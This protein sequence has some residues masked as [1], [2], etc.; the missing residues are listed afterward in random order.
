MIS[1]GILIFSVL[2]YKPLTYNRTYTYPVWAQ[3]LGWTLALVPMSV[4]PAHFFWDLYHRPGTLRQVHFFSK[5]FNLICA[6]ESNLIIY[7]CVL[8]RWA[9][10]TQ[11]VLSADHPDAPKSSHVPEVITAQL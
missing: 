7:L 6:F 2:A 3:A 1:Q 4:I 10:A 11:P 9:K 5:I 8:Q